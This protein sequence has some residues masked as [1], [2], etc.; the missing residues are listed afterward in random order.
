MWAQVLNPVECCRTRTAGGIPGHLATYGAKHS[1]P[2]GVGMPDWSEWVPPV[3]VP[4][5]PLTHVISGQSSSY[6]SFSIWRPMMVRSTL[7]QVGWGCQIGPR[8]FLLSALPVTLWPTLCLVK[9]HHLDHSRFASPWFLM[10]FPM[11]YTQFPCEDGI[12]W[13]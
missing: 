8:G 4:G 9:V 12:T 10:L 7:L 1:P 11:V 5:D 13:K 3:C 2:G 6:G